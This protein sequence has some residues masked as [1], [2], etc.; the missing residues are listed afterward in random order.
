VSESLHTPESRSALHAEFPVDRDQRPDRRLQSA[1]AVARVSGREPRY[2]PL[3][4]NNFGPRVGGVYRLTDKTILSAGLRPDLDRDGGHY[5]AVHHADVPV[6][7]ADRQPS[8]RS[9]PSTRPFVLAKGPS[10]AP[11]GQTADG[12]A[13]ARGSSRWTIRS[14]RGY[15]QQWNVSVQ[16][17][18]TTNTTVEASYVRLV[19]SPMSASPTQTSTSSTSASCRRA[20]R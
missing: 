15:V 16:R 19:S 2:G 11:I 18:L 13:S 17:E 12:K 4:K 5:H 7:S 20:H 1:D 14:G 3:K 10:V 9:T 8:A 6:S